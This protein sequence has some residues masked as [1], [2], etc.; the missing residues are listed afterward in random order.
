MYGPGYKS[1]NISENEPTEASKACVNFIRSPLVFCAI[2]AYTI[3]ATISAIEGLKTS[4]YI[5]ETFQIMKV[6]P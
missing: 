2:L 5:D 6:K 4:S 1:S 3:Y